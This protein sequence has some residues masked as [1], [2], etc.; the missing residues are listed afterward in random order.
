MTSK[1]VKESVL[2]EFFQA[3]Q[4]PSSNSSDS[5]NEDETKKSQPSISNL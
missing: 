5:E 2:E 3:I 1:K 4:V